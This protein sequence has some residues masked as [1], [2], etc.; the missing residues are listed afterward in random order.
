MRRRVLLGAAALGLAGP[1]RAFISTLDLQP[2]P[3]PAR[4]D[5]WVAPGLDRQVLIRWGD[6]VTFDA[7]PWDPRQPTPEGA[8]AQFGWDARIAGLVVPPPATDGVPRLIL[9]VG[10]PRV[11][12]AMA[13]P[14]LLDRPEL[15]AAM[16]GASLLN[17]A[18]AGDRWVVVDGGFQSR[19]LGADT[20]CRWTG[21]AATVPAVQ[22][23]LAPE[24]GCATPWGTLLLA[25]GDPRPWLARLLPLSPRWAEA[26]GY[27]WVTELD[28]LDPQAVPAKRSALGRIGAVAVAAAQA[29]DG[30]AVVFLADGRPLGFLYRFVAAGPAA[31]PDALD[32][33]TLQVARAEG[34]AIAWIALPSGAGLDPA[35]AAEAAGGTPFDTPCS[36]ALDPRGGRLL[37]AC[38][39]GSGR[40]PAA[41]DA[42]NPRAGAHPGHVVEITGSPEAARMAARVLFLA[43]S[44]AEG[45]RYGRDQPM[46]ALPR[47]PATLAVDGRGRLWVGTDRFGAPGPTADAVFACDLDGPGRAVLLPAYGAPLAGG[48]GGAMPTPEGDAVLATVRH[49]G[50]APGA[51]FDQPAT[52][53]PAF[54]PRLPPRAALLALS[55]PGGRPGR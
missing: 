46:A 21:P 54:D 22:G 37:L 51:S 29:A 2:A 41:V 24:G 10:H 27:G 19:R 26:A 30:R 55:R 40:S 28:P 13:W 5:D 3:V 47:Y 9:A 48:I 18:K 35:A 6:R 15:A 7:P 11:E 42:L 44:A 53:W 20:L 8:A 14:G 52:R 38:R 43:G 25:E 31:D 12:A 39:A 1:A 17:L 34:E 50:A 4:Q 33:G 45:G 49:P 23:L 16:Q 32:A 36:L